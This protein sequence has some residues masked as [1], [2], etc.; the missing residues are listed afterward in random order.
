MCAMMFSS[1]HLHYACYLSVYHTELVNRMNANP[2]VLHLLQTYGI[3][4][5]RSAVPG[6]RNPIDLT[7]EQKINR[8]A[9]TA[10]GIVGFS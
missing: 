8:S 1:D 2:E 10:G 9:K 7:I 5:S 4:I 6:C 3:S